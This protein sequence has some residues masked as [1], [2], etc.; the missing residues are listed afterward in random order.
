M[1]TSAKQHDSLKTDDMTSQK[2]KPVEMQNNPNTYRLKPQ[3]D[4]EYSII[5]WN[6]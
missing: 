6:L 5:K 1:S 4:V 2:F 3:A